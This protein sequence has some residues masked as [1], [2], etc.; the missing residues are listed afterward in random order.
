MA[1]VIPSV[2]CQVINNL[3]SILYVR[4][5]DPTVKYTNFE[6]KPGKTGLLNLIG[7]SMWPMGGRVSTNWLAGVVRSS[8]GEFM[9]TGR[10]LT[11][12]GWVL[13][14]VR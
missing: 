4:G 9:V 3:L 11:D 6:E 13:V 12:W 14:I 8:E 7:K 10:K 5:C 1:K 2:R